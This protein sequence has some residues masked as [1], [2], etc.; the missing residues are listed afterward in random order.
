M[1]NRV[2]S[3][4][5]GGL[6][7]IA[8]AT[9]VDVTGN[10]GTISG[11]TAIFA[12]GLARV[13]NLSGGQIN[14]NLFGI[15]TVAATSV[16]Q[17]DITNAAGATISAS[18][19][20]GVGI[21]GSG[22]V[23]SAGTITGGT[24]AGGASVQ[25]VGTGTNTLTLQGDS[26][27][28]GT[29]TGDAK[30]STSAG[31]TNKLIL[32]GTATAN[33]NFFD[34]TSLN[35][36]ANSFWVLNGDLRVGLTTIDSGAVLEVGDGGPSHSGAQLTGSVAVN[37]GGRLVGQGSINGSVGVLSGGTISPGVVVG[38]AIGTLTVIGNVS[39][40]AN[41]TFRV[42][43]DG[44]GRSSKLVATN[45]IVSL[46]AGTAGTPGPGVQVNAG[47][48]FAPSTQYNILHADRGVNGTFANV[49][50][51]LAF[52]TPTL[53]T[54]ANDVFLT[55]ACNATV[56]SSGG[57][58]TGGGGGGGGG[59]VNPG[60]GFAAVAQTRNENAVAGALDGGPV[61]NRLVIGLLN[62]TIAGARQAFDALSG[63]IFGSVQNIQAGQSQFTRDA[64]LGRMRQASYADAPAELGALSFGGPQLAYAGDDAYAADFPAKAPAAREPSRGLTFWA[65]GL[66]G[67]GHADSDGNA[68]SLRSRFGGFLSGAD[69]RF[70][71]TWRAGLVA[72]Y[73]RTDL[74][75]DARASSA[76]VDSVQFGG[77]AGG[78]VGAF[79]VRGG[80]SLT[81]DSIDTSRG[82]FFPGFSDQTHA[83]FHGNVGQVFGEVGYGMA[84]GQVA[85]EPLAGLAYVHVH[86]GS[87]AES[88]GAAA[89]SASA[90]NE[91][92]GHSSLGMRFASAVP[93]ANGT[94]LV[95]RGTVQWQHAFG[96]V[97]PVTGLAFQGTGATFTTAGI[98]I[99][100]DAALV[101]AGFDWRFSPQAKL[102]AFYQGE[103]AAHAQTHAF[104]GG[105][106]WDF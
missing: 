4:I 26:L 41:S 52:L 17:L 5:A 57:G 67:S 48:T 1:E 2:G 71:D 98:P 78:R 39:F 80:A 85:V 79:N 86:D 82:V 23:T 47:G 70:G 54:G 45:G 34:F 31:A 8:S 99:A 75:V 29:L 7:G 81:Y 58:G 53:T 19:I 16:G 25:F 61:S 13:H 74:N 89:L 40:G 12:I 3:T 6:A 27:G 90:S 73:T 63:E 96:D 32:Q 97:T 14:G 76:G 50:T 69:A 55:L 59:T 56:C 51:N 62:Q 103:L 95:P 65:L 102:G 104:K 49:T 20:N 100:R 28:G 106:T 66:G 68:A 10:A 36:Q 60:F 15:D 37:S 11:S 94:V 38:T 18:D 22:N 64:M 87:F 88:G 91:N 105:F 24:G 35:V 84:L 101:E 46:A 42:N 77:Y 43:V 44:D 72:G 30:G 9:T 21:R 33:N 92:L 93:L 83:H